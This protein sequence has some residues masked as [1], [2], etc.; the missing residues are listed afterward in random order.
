MQT[1]SRTISRGCYDPLRSKRRRFTA[2]EDNMLAQF[3]AQLTGHMCA[4]T[5]A[6]DVLSMNLF[7]LLRKHGWISVIFRGAEP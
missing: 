1:S 7:P 6:N 5:E 4:L 3:L 2:I